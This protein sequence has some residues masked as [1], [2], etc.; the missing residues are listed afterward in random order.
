MVENKTGY[1]SVPILYGFPWQL[2]VMTGVVSK[3][4]SVRVKFWS[5]LGGILENW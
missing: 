2:S 1:M 3:G 5:P 4:V